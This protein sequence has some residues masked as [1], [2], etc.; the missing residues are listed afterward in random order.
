[1]FDSM[2][3]P[4]SQTLWL[5]GWAVSPGSVQLGL[6]KGAFKSLPRDQAGT[7]S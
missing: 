5:G 7:S 1:M 3:F 6:R 4:G 2:L